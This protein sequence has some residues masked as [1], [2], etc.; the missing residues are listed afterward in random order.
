MRVFLNGSISGTLQRLKS[1]SNLSL[2]S[3]KYPASSVQYR[4]SRVVRLDREKVHAADGFYRLCINLAAPEL[5]VVLTTNPGAKA[6]VVFPLQELPK[7]SVT[8]PPYFSA[9]TETVAAY[10]R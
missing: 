5:S 6:V 8:S 3:L 7:G 1:P 2:S 9:T 10:R 4:A